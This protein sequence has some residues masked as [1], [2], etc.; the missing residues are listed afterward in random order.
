MAGQ[1]ERRA[2]DHRIEMIMQSLGRMENAIDRMAEAITKLAVI[3][4]RQQSDRKSIDQITASITSIDSRL[5]ALERAAPQ[6]AQVTTWVT[7]AVW[8][9]AG[10]AC[11]FVLNK[12]GIM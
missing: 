6:Q 7:S 2:E 10:I 4:E 12:L 5:D 11:V 9:A 3:E 8:A 1:Q